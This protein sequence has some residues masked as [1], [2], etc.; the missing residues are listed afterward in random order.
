MKQLKKHVS[1]RVAATVLAIATCL[2]VGTITTVAAGQPTQAMA[3][4]SWG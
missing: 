1:H 2:G 3:G 4:H